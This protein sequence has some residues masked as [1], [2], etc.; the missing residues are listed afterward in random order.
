MTVT[1]E[2]EKST[3]DVFAFQHTSP[4]IKRHFALCKEPA[5]LTLMEPPYHIIACN[6]AWQ[7]Q[8]GYKGSE[9]IGQTPKLLQGNM[10]DQIAANKFATDCMEI[11]QGRATLINYK[12]DGTSFAHKLRAL[13]LEGRYFLTEGV[14]LPPPPEIW[15]KL[16][17]HQTNRRNAAEQLIAI[18]SAL[19]LLY[20][21]AFSN[22][23]HEPPLLAAGFST[24]AAVWVKAA[25]APGA[26]LG[27]EAIALATCFLFAVFVA[28]L[29]ALDT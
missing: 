24:T 7:E 5:V 22:Y 15:K 2:H 21:F 23:A 19:M 29:S 3:W 18:Q 9:A 26:I 17:Q 6:S 28:A 16:A 14:A 4:S 27:S 13:K 12:K 25:S 11:G 20:F 10:T 8:C 1:I